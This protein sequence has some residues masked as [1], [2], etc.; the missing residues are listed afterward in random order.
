[1]WRCPVPQQPHAACMHIFNCTPFLKSWKHLLLNTFWS[2]L[3]VSLTALVLSTIHPPPPLSPSFNSIMRWWYSCG[4]VCHCWPVGGTG[5]PTP[6]WHVM[7]MTSLC[8]QDI[9]QFVRIVRATFR[10][11]RSNRR[12]SFLTDG[13]API[14][15]RLI[16]RSFI[17]GNLNF[18]FLL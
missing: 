9:W 3:F 11:C 2:D 1:M 7:M 6:A 8:D 10:F 16:N 5:V 12:W 13:M 18:A 17:A 15:H 14:Y 4:A